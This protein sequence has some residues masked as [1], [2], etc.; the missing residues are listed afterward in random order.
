M[1]KMLNPHVPWEANFDHVTEI[2]VYPGQSF[3]DLILGDWK[4][5]QVTF[6]CGM[7]FK[8][9]VLFGIKILLWILWSLLPIRM[10]CIVT[11]LYP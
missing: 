5:K 9:V 1:S 6:I 2:Y 10:E 8:M 7:L 3:L 11:G 4:V